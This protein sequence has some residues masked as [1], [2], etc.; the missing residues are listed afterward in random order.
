MTAISPGR[1]AATS[2]QAPCIF[3]WVS[4]PWLRAAV[5]PDSALTDSAGG[6]GQPGDGQGR[7]A[8]YLDLHDASL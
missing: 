4:T 5:E 6:E 3:A 8:A 1:W 7:L 2:T